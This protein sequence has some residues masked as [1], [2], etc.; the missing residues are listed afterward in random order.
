ML[1]GIYAQC[2]IQVLY[3]ECHFVECRYAERRYAECL[4]AED[5]PF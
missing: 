5:D 2:Q 4:S 1:S 3:A